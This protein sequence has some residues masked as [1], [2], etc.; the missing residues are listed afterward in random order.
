MGRGRFTSTLR[1]VSPLQLDSH[2]KKNLNANCHRCIAQPA[3][4]PSSARDF[5]LLQSLIFLLTN[6]MLHSNFGLLIT[7][8]ISFVSFTLV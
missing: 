6:F 3:D 8:Q 4:D 5:T 1:A 7:I 2:T